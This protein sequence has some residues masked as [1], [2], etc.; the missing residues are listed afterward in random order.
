MH[1]NRTKLAARAHAVGTKLERGGVV[2]TYELHDR[3]GA[4]RAS[5]RRFA[6]ATPPLD[7]TQR[8]IVD[9]LR[10]EGFAVLPFA[11][12]FPDPAVW[13][14]LADDGQRFVDETVAGLE[15]E[16][17]GGESGLRRTSKEFV[18]RKN[19]YGDTLALD[20][21]WVSLALA[22]RML[23]LA[24]T[25]L[26]LWSKLEYV[27]LWYT[28]PADAEAERRASQRWHRDYN[29]RHLLK[30]FIYLSDV[31]EEAGPFEYVPRSAPG[32]ELGDLW[33]WRPLG[34]NYPP[35]EELAE[36][37]AGRTV[38]T[39]TGPKGTMIFCN[40]SGFHRGGF[41]TGKP[42]ALATFTYSSP[43]SLRSLSDRNFTLADANGTLDAL[44]PAAR[45]AVS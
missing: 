22:P 7:E 9:A 31:D 20:D 36:R 14:R 40:T 27:D 34:Q 28:K 16:A 33:P 15:A 10:T 19:A 11:E 32:G 12:L 42:R 17:A 23:D 24:N 8:R 37:I 35:Q 1:R 26:G 4:N 25:Y 13:Q 3:L 45:F 5:R 2:A 38:E 21:P 43:A 41:A 6:S 29:D 39:F 18:V 44:P 30:A